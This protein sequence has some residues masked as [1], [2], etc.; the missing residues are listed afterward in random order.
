M[1][2]QTRIG[3]IAFYIWQYTKRPDPDDDATLS[4]LTLSLSSSR[5]DKDW[6]VQEAVVDAFGPHLFVDQLKRDLQDQTF[7][8]IKLYQLMRF[9]A[10]FATHP[11]TKRL[12]L[13]RGT[14]KLILLLYEGRKG[15]A[16]KCYG[17]PSDGLLS[18]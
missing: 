8:G 10:I 14:Y 17:R 9:L 1:F 6:L 13:E 18:R 12:A 7:T 4:L 15:K 5:S 11:A 16:K 2:T 3:H